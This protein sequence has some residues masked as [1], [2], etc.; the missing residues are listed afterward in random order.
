M[1]FASSLFIFLFLPLVLGGYFLVPKGFRNAFLLAASLIFYAWGEPVY[2]VILLC[3]ILL[4]YAGALFID[5]QR[6]TQ[7]ALLTDKF[8]LAICVAA[9]LGLLFYF[10]YADFF[11]SNLNG[12]FLHLNLRPLPETPIPLPL[13]IS[14][15]TFHA[16][17]YVVDV[18]RKE[19]PPQSNLIDCALYFALFTQLIAGPIIRYRDVAQ[20][21]IARATSSRQFSS[22]IQR[23]VFGLT[24]KVVLANPLG[25]VADQIF[26]LSSNDLRY[27]RLVFFEPSRCPRLSSIW[28]V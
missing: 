12:L 20:Q 17:S 27:D 13:G 19:T 23:F 14:F 24:K 21:I 5:R 18:Y 28:L 22:G 3:S 2:V 26:L 8:V 15:F 11:I 7:T 10:K 6:R 16:I 1:V 25:H 4:N 9:N